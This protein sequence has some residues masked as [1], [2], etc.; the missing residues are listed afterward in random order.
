MMN[1]NNLQIEKQLEI[2]KIK[3]AADCVAQELIEKLNKKNISF[4]K[5]SW[6]SGKQHYIL[7][8]VTEFGTR[9]CRFGPECLLSQTDPMTQQINSFLILQLVNKLV[10]LKK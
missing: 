8:V 3:A 6:K 4:Q 1:T 10:S 7:T 9:F 5:I 2:D